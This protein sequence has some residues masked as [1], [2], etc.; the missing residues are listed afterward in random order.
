MP[1]PAEQGRRG[2]TVGVDGIRGNLYLLPAG[3]GER[4]RRPVGPVNR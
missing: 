1:A 3:D 2:S 4:S